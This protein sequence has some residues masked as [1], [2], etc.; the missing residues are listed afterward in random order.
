MSETEHTPEKIA[1]VSRRS[2]TWL[3]GKLIA[4]IVLIVVVLLFTVLGR[5]F[6]D[7]TLARVASCSRTRSRTI[8]SEPFVWSQQ[9]MR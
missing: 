9:E 1:T 6:W 5:L 3:N 7:V 4:G 2:Y 8:S